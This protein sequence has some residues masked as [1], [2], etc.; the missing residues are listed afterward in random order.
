MRTVFALAGTLVIGLV[1]E[2]EKWAV[3]M[4]AAEGALVMQAYPRLLPRGN[5][6]MNWPAAR[7]WA[8]YSEQLVQLDPTAT[9]GPRRFL[10]R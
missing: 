10:A 5:G 1:G 3:P 2:V 8:G 9:S 7:W 4:G 6:W